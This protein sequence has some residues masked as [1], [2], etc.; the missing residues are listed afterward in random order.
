MCFQFRACFLSRMK[1]DDV[2]LED[3]ERSFAPYISDVLLLRKYYAGTI[4]VLAVHHTVLCIR[5]RA[6]NGYDG[7]ESCVYIIDPGHFEPSATNPSRETK[8]SS[9]HGER[10]MIIFPDQLTTSRMS[11]LTRLIHTYFE[12]STCKY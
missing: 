2:T 4:S 6:E 10:E 11:N 3:A 7:I 5:L 8:Y 12:C 1:A 9:S